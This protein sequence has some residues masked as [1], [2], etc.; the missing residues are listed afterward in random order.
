MTNASK[1][2]EGRSLTA[3]TY[4]DS[5]HCDDGITSFD[6]TLRNHDT[7]CSLEKSCSDESTVSNSIDEDIEPSSSGKRGSGVNSQGHD[8]YSILTEVKR[9]SL[10][11][12][13]SKRVVLRSQIRT[14][15]QASVTMAPNS[16]NQQVQ[17]PPS[18]MRQPS[19]IYVAG[20]IK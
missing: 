10:A 16:P 4:S 9:R 6:S 20:Q 19:S 5:S 3:A 1:G 14:T 12:L 17:H 7:N 18:S 15:V 2:R 8:L 13:L 11:L